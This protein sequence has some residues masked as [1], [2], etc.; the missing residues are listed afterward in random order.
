MFVNPWVYDV[1]RRLRG[2]GL[3]RGR[4]QFERY[5]IGLSNARMA[6]IVTTPL[7]PLMDHER[8]PTPATG[9]GGVGSFPRATW[10]GFSSGSPAGSATPL[11]GMPM[12]A[13]PSI[14]V[15]YNQ[16]LPVAFD[17]ASVK[18]RA[19]ALLGFTTDPAISAATVTWLRSIVNKPYELFSRGSY[20]VEFRYG[21]FGCQDPDSPIRG[22]TKAF[23]Y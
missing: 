14:R 9:T 11:H 8:G 6:E 23:T 13:S 20:T 5:Q 15:Q 10:P 19:A 7:S 21:Y 16:G 18:I 22:H 12:V 2:L 4:V 1:I 3:W 17:Y